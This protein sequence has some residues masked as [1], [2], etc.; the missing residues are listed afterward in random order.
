MAKNNKNQ[1]KKYKLPEDYLKYIKT[2]GGGLLPSKWVYVFYHKPSDKGD[3]H[4][5]ETITAANKDPQSPIFF[6]ARDAYEHY[7]FLKSDLEK[8]KKKAP[9]Y[10]YYH[11]TGDIE[12]KA[13]SFEDFLKWVEKVK[14]EY[15]K[16]KKAAGSRKNKYNKTA[17]EVKKQELRKVAN[18]INTLQKHTTSGAGIGAL[19]GGLLAPVIR[20]FEPKERTLL[21]K[22]AVATALSSPKQKAK[23]LKKAGIAEYLNNS[24]I[25]GSPI[26]RGAG[27]GALVGA[28]LSPAVYFMTPE[29]KR[30]A[31]KTLVITALS[32]AGVGGLGGLAYRQFGG[33]IEN[34]GNK[35]QNSE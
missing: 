28:L 24:M 26:T 21:L 19:V 30:N 13:D 6:V 15:E 16:Q 8:G 3:F 23:I 27:I 18:A 1:N 25:F 31:L 9:V 32:G 22:T 5:D 34:S 4:P 20:E 35:S 12:K 7:G 10:K 14:E 11:E 2:K 17:N 29:E 33:E